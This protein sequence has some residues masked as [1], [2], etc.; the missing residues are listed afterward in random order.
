MLVSA[1]IQCHFDYA[2]S[3]WFNTITQN[4]KTKLI[5]AQNK[6]MHFVLGK[7]YRDSLS[8]EDYK[9]AG[10]L[11]LTSR[12]NTLMLGRMYKIRTSAATKYMVDVNNFLILKTC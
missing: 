8:L 7:Q 1:I 2:C 10:D 12:V 6:G 9:Q 5:R 11:P 4:T 3:Y